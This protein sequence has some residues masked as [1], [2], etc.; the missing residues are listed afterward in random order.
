[1]PRPSIPTALIG[2]AALITGAVALPMT[3]SAQS[4]PGLSNNTFIASQKLQ[5]SRGEAVNTAA[6][7]ERRDQ[8]IASHRAQ[9]NLLAAQA[10][11]AAQPM[12]RVN[13]GGPSPVSIAMP[14]G[15]GLVPGAGPGGETNYHVNI[16]VGE[17]NQSAITNTSIKIDEVISSGEETGT[18]TG[19]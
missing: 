5:A 10:R 4:A 11:A 19:D 1:M 17:G 6:T 13:T 2:L 18:E 3:A 9:V 15:S 14:T 8:A 12:M 7:S 16:Q